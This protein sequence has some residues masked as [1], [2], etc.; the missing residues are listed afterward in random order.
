M[1]YL[2]LTVTMCKRDQ[3]Q[4]TYK[5]CKCQQTCCLASEPMQFA[6][7]S[8]HSC[9]ALMRCPHAVHCHDFNF[10]GC[11]EVGK[12]SKVD[13][14]LHDARLARSP[15]RR[16]SSSNFAVSTCFQTTSRVLKEPLNSQM[17]R[18]H[19]VSKD[20]ECQTKHHNTHPYQDL[21]PVTR[22]CS[23][24]CSKTPIWLHN[25]SRGCNLETCR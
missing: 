16:L 7:P 5:R 23:K 11:Y 14:A 22:C 9:L 10:F 1:L 6:R 18:M 25:Y 2:H 4:Q 19:W 20:L 3:W 8:N 24:H 17:Q 15:S 13:S 12:S 21:P